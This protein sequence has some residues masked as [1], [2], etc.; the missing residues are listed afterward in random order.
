MADWYKYIT[1]C[2]DQDHLVSTL[3]LLYSHSFTVKNHL[4]FPSTSDPLLLSSFVAGRPSFHTPQS[5]LYDSP[6][7]SI[8][9][10]A[11]MQFSIIALL[12][13]VALASAAPLVGMFIYSVYDGR[14]SLRCHHLRKNLIL[15]TQSLSFGIEA[16]QTT[17]QSDPH[18]SS[19]KQ[20]P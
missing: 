17:R 2:H 3:L 14:C 13:I 1:I 5:I 19:L 12:S 7:E 9:T 15:W 6:H 16:N 10:S 4:S 20:Q 11:I 18:K 8:S